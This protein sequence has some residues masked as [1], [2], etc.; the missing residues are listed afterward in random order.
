MYVCTCVYMH[1][2]LQNAI[3]KFLDTSTIAEW[4]VGVNRTLEG[5]GTRLDR[6]PLLCN[7][8]IT[9]LVSYNRLVWRSL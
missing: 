9:I 7:L 6:A 1:A 5:I 2:M 8:T 4:H 3:V